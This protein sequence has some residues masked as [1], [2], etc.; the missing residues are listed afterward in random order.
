MRH[1]FEH[2][3]R[4]DP[5][6]TTMNESSIST[7]L[8]ESFRD[9]DAQDSNVVS[10]PDESNALPGSS[11]PVDPNTSVCGVV[12]LTFPFFSFSIFCIDNP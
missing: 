12:F 7:S 6:E 11:Y 3:T 2:P 4:D 10:D 1:S 9:Q 8:D 5:G